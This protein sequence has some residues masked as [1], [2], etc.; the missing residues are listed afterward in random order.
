MS[1]TAPA[2]PG[3]PCAVHLESF[4]GPVDLLMHMAR[5]G[6]IDITAIPILEVTRQYEQYL[7]LMRRIDLDAAGECLVIVAA[8]V[9]MKSRLLLPPDPTE[10]DARPEESFEVD[11]PE[12]ARQTLRKATEMLQ[13][14]EALMELAYPRPSDA[15]AEFSGEQGIE[16]DLFSLLR[17]FQAILRRMGND[18]AARITR[19]RITLVERISW[20][21]ETLQQKRRVGFRALFADVDDRILCILTFLALLEVMRLR[22]VRAFESHHHADLLIVLADDVPSPAEAPG[23]A[24]RA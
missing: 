5:T 7:D 23:E 14:R 1:E 9:H 18:P 2:P 22:L 19:D 3:L 20:L 15:V 4:Q 8:L 10:A 16:A 11:R 21:L 13:E 17:A 6:A 24:P 12:T